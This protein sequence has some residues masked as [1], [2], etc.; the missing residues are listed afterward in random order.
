MRKIIWRLTVPGEDLGGTTGG[1]LSPPI[2]LPLSKQ[3][4]KC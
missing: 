4:N 3:N 2:D 1:I